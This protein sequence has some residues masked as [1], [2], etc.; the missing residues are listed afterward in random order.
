MRS[1]VE[2]DINLLLWSDA[3]IQLLDIL[4]D[5]QAFA[6]E[7]LIERCSV[8]TEAV[9]RGLDQL[10]E[11]LWIQSQDTR[12]EMTRVGRLKMSAYD[13]F[14]AM[15][16]R[17]SPATTDENIGVTTDPRETLKTLV[18]SDY[19]RQIAEFL[20]DRPADRD[21]IQE[22]CSASGSSLSR[23]LSDLMDCGWVQQHPTNRDY[24]LVSPAITIIESWT[25]F[26]HSLRVI[27]DK[28]EFLILLRQTPF[29]VSVDA[30]EECTL[31]V[32]S[33]D[34]PHAAVMDFLST[35]EDTQSTKFHA[36]VPILSDVYNRAAEPLVGSDID[37]ELIIDEEVLHL[38]ETN[39]PGNVATVLESDNIDLYIHPEKIPIGLAIL[40]DKAMMGAYDEEGNHR[41]SLVGSSETATEWMNGV[42]D[43]YKS[44]TTL[45]TSEKIP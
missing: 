25:G 13:D 28:E 22:H 39:A 32:A 3:R 36:M 44:R 12:Y 2:D 26:A 11:S 40:D 21:E 30:L 5:G 45:L 31:T 38:S 7:E 20:H 9:D 17:L 14:S 35:L 27:N 37:V 4:K 8:G 1:D 24:Y 42:F 16:G 29:A 15:L 34:D 41:A 10:T 19:R 23:C 6:R 18:N 33:K 43:Q